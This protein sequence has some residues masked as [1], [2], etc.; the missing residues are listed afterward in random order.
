MTKRGKRVA[1]SL[2]VTLALLTTLGIGCGDE[3]GGNGGKVEII[4]GHISDMTGPAATALV[5][6][7]YAAKDLAKY[8][9]DNELIEGATIKIVEYDARYDPAYDIPGWEWIRSKGAKIGLT[10]LPTTAETLKPVAARDKMPLWAL[11]YSEVLDDPAGWVFLANCPN[12]GLINPLMKWISENDP[13]FPTDRPAKVGSAGWNEPYAIACKNAIQEYATAHPDKWEYVGG[14]LAPTGAVTWSSEVIGL[15]DCDYVWP[16]STGT[17]VPTFINQFRNSGGTATFYGTDAQEA[18]MGLIVDASGWDR[19]DGTL[20]VS[21]TRWWNETES[22][23][24]DLALTLLETN[25]P[26]EKAEFMHAGVGYVG[27]FHQLYALFDVLKQAVADAGGAE[28]FTSQSFY[29]TAQNFSMQWPTYEEWTLEPD[30]RYTWNY[31]GMYKWSKAD[32]DVV[33]TE[34]P[35]YTIYVE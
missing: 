16:P 31:V 7:N 21:P 10:A 28:N 25:H 14:Y 13:N 24:V 29:D 4:I 5:P 32:Q 6:I 19:I 3:N 8:Y 15:K 30:K 34:E 20:A 9:N 11:S 26:D 12:R 17:G 22:P 33:R 1:V 18:Y 23:I 35:W 27:G 2:L